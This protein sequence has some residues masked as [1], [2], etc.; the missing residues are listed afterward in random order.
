MKY[1][2]KMIEDDLAIRYGSEAKLFS[3]ELLLDFKYLDFRTLDVRVDSG[4]KNLNIGELIIYELISDKEREQIFTSPYDLGNFTTLDSKEV[5]ESE[6]VDH[7]ITL[8]PGKEQSELSDVIKSLKRV[9]FDLTGQKYIDYTK[10]CV[11]R[12]DVQGNK[13]YATKVL[14][15]FYRYRLQFPKIFSRFNKPSSPQKANLEL[16]DISPL[17]WGNIPQQGV[18]IYSDLKLSLTHGMSSEER[19]RLLPTMQR[20]TERYERS[21]FMS[22]KFLMKNM[23]D[24]NRFRFDKTHIELKLPLG[25]RTLPERLDKSAYVSL[26]LRVIEHRAVGKQFVNNLLTSENGLVPVMVNW[27]QK[28]FEAMHEDFIRGDFQGFK[29]AIRQFTG[30]NY[31]DDEFERADELCKSLYFIVKNPFEDNS[32]YYDSLEGIAAIISCLG[33]DIEKIECKAYW[34]GKK[35]TSDRPVYYL[36]SIKKCDDLYRTPEFYQEYWFRRYTLMLSRLVEGE[37]IWHQC[38]MLEQLE[39]ERVTRV[40]ETHNYDKAIELVNAYYDLVPSFT[41]LELKSM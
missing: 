16:R 28:A 41:N 29:S 30:K 23:F 25:N 34:Y 13:S 19:S 39:I 3:R 1:F 17:R 5:R 8:K 26:V 12:P 10:E 27:S 6:I 7:L 31:S 35:T 14:C 2:I 22:S 24:L 21:V 18:S 4:Y 33:Y 20:I 37:S 9:I 15:T 36:E 32:N 38:N 40:F 11:G